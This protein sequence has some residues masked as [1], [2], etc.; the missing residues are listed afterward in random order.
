MQNIIEFKRNSESNT[1]A[2]FAK[3]LH[4]VVVERLLEDSNLDQLRGLVRVYQGKDDA[5]VLRG[6]AKNG[7]PTKRGSIFRGVSRNGKNF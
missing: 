4:E 3:D 7:N 1:N 2:P 6:N 5:I